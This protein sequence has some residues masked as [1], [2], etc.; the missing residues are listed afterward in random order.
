VPDLPHFRIPFS[1]LGGSFAAVEQDTIED[2]EQC[3]EA[4]CR[5]VIGSR[6][7]AP[8][9]GIPDETFSKQT[10]APSPTAV[11]E[12]VEGVEPRARLLAAAT[13]EDMIKRITLRLRPTV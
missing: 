2:V 13:V 7:D 9:Y 12:A 5:T 1:A 11:L 8:G 6:T 4:A 10:P 3:V